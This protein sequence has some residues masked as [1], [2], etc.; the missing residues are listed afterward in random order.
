MQSYNFLVR[1]DTINKCQRQ[2]FTVYCAGNKIR[3]EV[4]TRFP[5]W[6]NAMYCNTD[7]RCASLPENW[8][9]IYR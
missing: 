6:Q 9:K 7:L 5:G 1:V 8:G 2:E 4:E 3:H